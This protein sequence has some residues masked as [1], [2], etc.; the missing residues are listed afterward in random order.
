L[1]H[2]S[3]PEVHSD[4]YAWYALVGSAGAAI[5][6][7]TCG[8][9]IRQLE[10]LEGWDEVQ[11]YK[12]V[13][14][15]YAGLGLIKFFLAITLSKKVE[16]EKETPLRQSDPERAPLLTESRANGTDGVEPGQKKPKKSITSILPSISSESRVIVVNLCILFALDAFASS[17]VSL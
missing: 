1:A 17:L 13:F 10:S 12:M 11:A 6:M 4:I 8:W 15:V 16:L 3:P 5:G 14:F 2:L 9:A 7:I